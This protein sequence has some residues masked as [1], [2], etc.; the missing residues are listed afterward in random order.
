MPTINLTNNT[1]LNLTASSADGNAALNRY[2]QS[3]LTFKTPP[4][5]DPIVRSLV[6]DQIET[7]FPITV[8]ALGEGKF[9]VKGSILDVQIGASAALG[10]LQDSDESSFLSTVEMSPDP[11]SSGLVSF[12]VAGTVSAGP[13][14]TAGKFTFGAADSTTVTLTSYYRAAARDTLGDAVKEAIIALSIPHDLDDLKCL[15]EGTICQIDATGSLTFSASFTYSFLNDPLAAASIA[16]IPV[17]GVTA[18]ASATIEGTATHTSNHTLTIAKLPN[19]L[20]HLAVSLTKTNDF[21]TCLTVSSGVSTDIAGQDPL[22]FLL[23]KIN[24]NSRAEADAIASQ[25]K[26]PAKFKADIKSA[27]DKT[28]CASLSASL[29]ATLET[30]KSRNRAFVYEIDLKAL[31]SASKAALIA[32]LDGNFTDLTRTGVQWKGIKAL[33]S[34]LTV[35]NTET[36]TIAVHLLGILN[37]SSIHEFVAQSTIDVTSDTHELVLSDERLQ[38]V[39]NNLDAEKLRKLVL[40]DVTLTLPASAQTKQA[41]TPL[42]LVFL[43]RD[44]STSASKMRQFGNVLDTLGAPASGAAQ[45]LLNRRLKNYA[46]CSLF[47][48]LNLNPAQCHALFLDPSSNAYGSMYYLDAICAAER[49]I[50]AGLADDPENAYHLKLFHASKGSW[51][52]LQ[53][54]GT[55]SNMAPTLRKL[56]MNDTEV[57]LAATEAFT[58]VW[59]AGAMADYAEALAKGRS[60][61]AVGKE[62]VKESNL[63]Y[64][65]PWM[66]LAAWNLAGKPQVNSQFS[67]SLPAVSI[68][69]K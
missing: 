29:K 12:A 14:V 16:S 63:G 13:E 21:E 61:E 59:W 53:E 57:Q 30:N 54:A 1:D 2:L 46:T 67:C 35:V 58:A 34:A 48:G 19:G 5:L 11:S 31:D 6:K 15:P 52:Q 51:Q 62:V 8:S 22:A 69:A 20:L 65:D 44:A 64:S 28:L 50:Y 18:G 42:T 55:A 38:V 60:L 68:A 23:D 33:D 9:A 3:M 24:P 56:G 10:L 25:M 26:D 41:D 66:I 27:I 32:A 36:H 40:K 43:E 49:A 39:D 37:A 17:L 47:L 7:D 45:A 4:S